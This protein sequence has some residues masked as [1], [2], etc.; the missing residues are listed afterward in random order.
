MPDGQDF[1]PYEVAGPTMLSKQPVNLKSKNTPE[2]DAGDWA[3][4]FDYLESRLGAL[5]VVRYSWWTYWATLAAYILPRRYRWLITANLLNKGDPINQNII[6]STGTLAMNIC[7]A[8]FVDGVMP[9]TRPWVKIRVG[10]PGQELPQDAKAWCEDTEEKFY[11]VVSQSNFYDTMAQ[12]SQDQTTFGTAPVIVYEDAETIIRCYNPCA[13]EYYLA[14]SSRFTVDT[15]YREFVLTVVEIVEMFQIENCPAQVVEMWNTGGSSLENEFVVAHAIEPNFAIPRKG[16]AGGKI[17]VCKGKFPFREVYWLKGVRT[18]R[19][20]TIKGF[21]EKP[22]AVGRWSK[23]ANDAYGRGPG[24][25]ALGDIKQ[26]QMETMRKAEAIEKMVRPPMVAD[27]SMKNEP[28]S[29]LPGHITYTAF[30]DGKRPSF[31]PA[32]EVDPKIGELKEDLMGIQDRI[33][34]A[35]LVDVFM[36]ISQMEGVQPRNDLEIVERRAEKLQRLGPVIG[37]WKSEFAPTIIERILNIM[38]RRG[39]LKPRPKSMQGQ[40]LRFEYLD[41]VTMAQVGAQTVSMERTFKTAGF[42]SQAAKLA[43]V[44]DPMRKI[45]LDKSLEV[46]GDKV[47][48]PT[49]CMYSDDEVRQHDAE[50]AKVAAGQQAAEMALPAVQAAKSLSETDVGGGQS[51]LSMML[52]T[53]G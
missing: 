37:L 13:G 51:A 11:M 44:P 40:A 3:Q 15:L 28:S 50:R 24:M 17:D 5:R 33:N 7:S 16:K 18:E 29:I 52:N 19:P 46:Y 4:I 12:S 38:E 30:S 27:V 9:S 43:G 26:L 49:I 39:I 48:F 45:N 25:D 41:I 36:A 1:A 53:G 34:R 2:Y 8:G 23:V 32:F 47:K 14:S 6:D 21:V 20:L 22:F 35:F 10:K 42:L 31:M